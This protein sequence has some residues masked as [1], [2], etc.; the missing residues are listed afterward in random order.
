[1]CFSHNRLYEWNDTVPVCAEVRETLCRTRTQNS[2]TQSK[3]VCQQIWKSTKVY[4][5][6]GRP[7]KAAF[8]CKLRKNIPLSH[9]VSLQALNRPTNLD[10]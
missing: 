7:D 8:I 3:A 1:M 4:K 5:N 2:L 6:A 10:F 9:T